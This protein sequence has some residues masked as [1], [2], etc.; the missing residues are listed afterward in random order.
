MRPF[1]LTSEFE[2]SLKKLDKNQQRLILKRMDKI[3]E[4]PDLG[5]PL[6]APMQNYRSERVEKFRIIYAVR[7]ES[8]YFAFLANRKHVYDI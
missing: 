5:K 1:A 7:G 8:I 6:H 2:N 4:M 3:L